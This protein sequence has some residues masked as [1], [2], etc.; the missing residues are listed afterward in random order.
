MHSEHKK[1]RYKQKKSESPLHQVTRPIFLWGKWRLASNSEATAC[2][3]KLLYSMND[4][5]SS[6]NKCLSKQSHSLVFYTLYMIREDVLIIAWAQTLNSS[7]FL[8]Q[9]FCTHYTEQKHSAWT[10][11]CRG[12]SPYSLW[13]IFSNSVSGDR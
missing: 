12:D 2:K 11:F 3:L 1:R 5:K 6:S 8:P 13:P 10:P 4:L 7:C 9:S